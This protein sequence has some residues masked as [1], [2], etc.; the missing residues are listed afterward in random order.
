MGS[1]IVKDVGKLSGFTGFI[2]IEIG[3]AIFNFKVFPESTV[4]D[5]ALI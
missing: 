5:L 1:G 3:A 2:P 4:A